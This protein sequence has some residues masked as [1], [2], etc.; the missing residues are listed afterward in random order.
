[1]FIHLTSGKKWFKPFFLQATVAQITS[2]N[3]KSLCPWK[4]TLLSCLTNRKTQSSEDKKEKKK[5][6]K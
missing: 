2:G 3:A 6:P 5:R 1:M 4:T